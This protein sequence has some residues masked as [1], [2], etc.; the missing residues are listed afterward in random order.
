MIVRKRTLIVILIVKISTSWLQLIALK[1]SVKRFL[2]WNGI[3]S[4]LIWCNQLRV[5]WRVWAHITTSGG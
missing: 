3:P 2:S 1:S 5:L 4:G